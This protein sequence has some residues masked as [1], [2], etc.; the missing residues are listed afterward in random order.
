MFD[1]LP[2]PI[3]AEENDGEFIFSDKVYFIV[4]KKFSNI[5]F[6]ELAKTLWSN[7]TAGKSVLE[8]EKRSD[9][10]GKALISLSDEAVI[11]E[12]KTDFEYEIDCNENG[13]SIL[14]SAENGLIHAFFTILQIV[15]PF[16]RKTKDFSIPF[17]EI[18]D[19]PALKMRGMHLCVFHGVPIS[20]I[21]KFVMLCG[22]LKCSHIILEFWGSLKYDSLSVLGWPDAYEKDDFNEVISIGKAMG[23]EFIPFFN[24]LGHAPQSRAKT[25]KHSVLNQAPEYEEWF[26]LGGW[27]WDVENEE[28]NEL[29][30]NIRNELSEMFREGEFVHIGCDEF[31]DHFRLFGDN[32]EQESKAFVNFLNNTTEDVR[33]SLNRKTIMWGE[34]FLDKKDFAWPFCGNTNDDFCYNPDGLTDDIYIVDWQYNIKEDKPESVEYFLKFKDPSKLILAP[35]TGRPG[36]KGRCNL[37]KKYGCFGVLGTTW[38]TVYNEISDM[39][40][41]AICMWEEDDSPYEDDYSFG[42]YTKIMVLNYLRKL[43]PETEY[44]KAGV[45][46]DDLFD[47][48]M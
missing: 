40:Y 29:H 19:R 3:I 15:S 33:K 45:L 24:H 10:K 14:Y 17:V 11:T 37:A 48:K 9:I 22:F 34:M 41:T 46:K 5:E 1:L 43:L 18:K 31:T 13:I 6:L 12:A 26:K 8:I 25:G 20:L 16:R 38:N 42:V 32:D 47:V 36:I 2:R 21:K 28:V 44:D 30:H 4:D 7:F 39:L 23:M 35:W 27:T